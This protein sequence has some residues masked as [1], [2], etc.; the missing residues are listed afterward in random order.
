MLICPPVQVDKVIIIQPE[1]FELPRVG[2]GE[3][4]EGSRVKISVPCAHVGPMPVNCRLISYE[5]REGQV[6]VET[7]LFTILKGSGKKIK[8][9]ILGSL[10]GQMAT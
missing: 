6:N 7:T 1:S 4:E 9:A 5:L 8:N 2:G 10:T 3:E